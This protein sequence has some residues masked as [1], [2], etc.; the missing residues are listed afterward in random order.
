MINTRESV[1]IY[2][3]NRFW[4]GCNFLK[5]AFWTE[6]TES[7]LAALLGNSDEALQEAADES[8]DIKDCQVSA[9]VASVG[10]QN[11][12]G[13]TAEPF[14]NPGEIFV[15]GGGSNPESD[16]SCFAG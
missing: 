6:T 16:V 4:N 10:E 3:S 9:P 2:V 14:N 7:A 13:T 15:S 1:M 5:N 12:L 11:C 8:S